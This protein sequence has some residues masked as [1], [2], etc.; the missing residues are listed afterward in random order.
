M[1]NKTLRLALIPICT[2]LVFLVLKNKIVA[3]SEIDWDI[4]TTWI[5]ETF[6]PPLT[7]D[8]TTYEI[9]D[10][11]NM[12]GKPVFVLQ[13]DNFTNRDYIYINQDSVWFYDT[14]LGD[15]QL[16]YVFNETT[17]YESSW[18]GLGS[19]EES[20]AL[21]DIDSIYSNEGQT[22]QSLAISNSGTISNTLRIESING[23]GLS[24]G[25]LKLPLGMGLY[26]PGE[27]VETL[28]CFK[29]KDECIKF[30]DYDCEDSW[31]ISNTHEVDNHELNIFPNPSNGLISFP[32]EL[33]NNKFTLYNSQGL[34]VLKGTL[35]ENPINLSRHLKGVYFLK[36]KTTNKALISKLYL[37]E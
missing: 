27:F 36:I 2:C 26:D 16:T 4:G 9:I 3:Q 32:E 14:R 12:L 24:Y 8:F 10:T 22:Y 18:V 15:F 28:R 19:N 21:I 34:L 30:V 13:R 23:I 37:H 20:I 35:S 33:L 6:R 31:V 25:G 29:N 11:T 7:K 17:S 1:K 5:Y